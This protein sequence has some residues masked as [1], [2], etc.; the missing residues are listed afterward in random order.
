MVPVSPA[1]SDF[2]SKSLVSDQFPFV[3]SYE[4]WR[5]NNTRIE[6]GAFPY[7]TASS[8]F[9]SAIAAASKSLSAAM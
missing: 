1:G 3:I 9:K 6:T 7:R 2:T 5:S 8:S 4:G